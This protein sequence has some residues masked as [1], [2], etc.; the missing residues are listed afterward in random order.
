LVVLLL[1]LQY[2]SRESGF[3]S[4]A[5]HR[6]TTQFGRTE[7]LRVSTTSIYNNAKTR[8]FVSAESEAELISQVA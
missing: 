1:A 2:F 3:W 4:E 6:A 5:S 8:V 7:S